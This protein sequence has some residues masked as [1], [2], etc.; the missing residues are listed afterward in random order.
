MIKDERF[1]PS[2]KIVTMALSP[3]KAKDKTLSIVRRFFA[4]RLD[5]S[6]PTLPYDK[7]SHYK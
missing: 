5:T 1:L 7:I 2:C 4:Y 3:L 6:R